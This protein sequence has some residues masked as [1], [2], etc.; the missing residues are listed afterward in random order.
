M[1]GLSYVVL[2]VVKLL[3]VLGFKVSPV[4]AKD[5]V[6]LSDITK[7]FVIGFIT[8]F[9]H[10]CMIT[11]KTTEVTLPVTTQIVHTIN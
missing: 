10:G 6:L 9:F 5:M 1:S 2:E 7:L 8:L 3:V 4:E 11:P